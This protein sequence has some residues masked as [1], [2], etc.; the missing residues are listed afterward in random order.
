MQ[1]RVLT[2]TDVREALPMAQA[3]AAM[4]EAFRQY[5][6][7]EADVP[8]RTRLE[9]PGQS[10]LTLIM[11]AYLRRTGDMAVKIVSVFSR[12]PERALPTILAA[13]LVIDSSSGQP[14]ALLEGASLT[15]L[16][17]GAAS[18]AATDALA[19]PDSAVLAVFGSGAQARTQAEAVCTVRAIR[20]VWVYSLDPSGAQRMIEQLR[21]HRPM[22]DDF[23]LAASPVEAAGQADV[24]CT[25]TTSARPVFPDSALKAGAHI[26]AIGSYTPEMQEID[27]RTVQRARVVVDSRQAAL[28]ETGDLI[29]PIRA[30]VITADHIHAELGEVLSG[31]APGRTDADQIT[32]FKS[33][34]LAVQDAVAAGRALARA[35]E[36]GLGQTVEL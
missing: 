13:V 24:V 9:V 16:R 11:P 2:A 18:G 31:A 25:A 17:T 3:V 33:V 10:G 4:Q 32:L 12:N 7:G 29:L 14:L 20:Q 28:A 34:G 1:L 15:A 30:G 35:Q 27:P 8:L 5:S 21:G 22:P 6:S 26:N 36:L 19:R 23:R